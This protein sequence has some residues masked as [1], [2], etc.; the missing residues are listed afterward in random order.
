VY[1]IQLDNAFPCGD[2]VV[3]TLTLSATGTTSIF[4]TITL[5]SGVITGST[6]LLSENF[7]AVLPPALPTGWSSVNGCMTCSPNDWTTTATNFLSAPNAA[8]VPDAVFTSFGRLYG[9]IVAVPADA[10]YVDVE[11]D[12]RW[13]LE[14]QDARTAFDAFSWEYQLN[15]TG[16]SRFATS[17]AVEFENRYTHYVVRS[18]GV[19]VGD[20]SGWSGNNLAFQHVRI[21]IVGLAGQTMIPRFSLSTDSN[22][23]ASG[24]WVDNVVITAHQVG[25][26][27]SCVTSVEEGTTRDV[28][29]GALS[30]R[31]D[32]VQPVRGPASLRYTLPAP[33]HVQ[34][35]L[36]NVAGRRVRSLASGFAA[37]G[38]HVAH[39]NSRSEGDL[40]P[41]M[42]LARLVTG[43]ESR[44]VRFVVTD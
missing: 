14:A 37:G 5:V 10:Q 17:E 42:Y 39:F 22:T 27:T 43:G 25:C 13:D 18:S 3:L 6:V 29:S 40:A 19:N 33:A 8:F 4:Q 31:L 9:P 16:G 26:G 23:G 1:Q 34:L 44:V 41:G 35:D 11:F 36:F 38:D 20:R 15:A 24:L 12:A 30:L 2:S 28:A 32:G 7:D 21:R